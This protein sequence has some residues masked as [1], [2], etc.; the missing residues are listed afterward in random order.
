MRENGAS[1][2]SEELKLGQKQW[3]KTM[4]DRSIK[5][6]IRVKSKCTYVR[7]RTE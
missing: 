4:R 5:I 2:R 1:N 3:I 6:Y 7:T